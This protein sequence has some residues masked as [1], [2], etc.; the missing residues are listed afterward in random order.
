MPAGWALQQWV[1]GPTA[2]G[3]CCA[4]GTLY[5]GHERARGNDRHVAQTSP[6]TRPTL[7]ALSIPALPPQAPE[8][9]TPSRNGGQ[10]QRDWGL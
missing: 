6:G 4:S 8:P 5:W 2:R 3:P 7:P 9:Q 10:P 1:P